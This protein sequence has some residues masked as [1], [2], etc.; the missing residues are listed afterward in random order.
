MTRA[1]KKA[2]DPSAQLSLQEI[3][4]RLAT[5]LETWKH[6]A[7][8]KAESE[9]WWMEILACYGVEGRR[10]R[11]VETQYEVIR[12]DTG[13]HGWIDVFWPGKYLIE[14]KSDGE[15]RVAPGAS[16]SNAEIQ[17][18]AYL[19]GG[20]L[21]ENQLPRYLV[22]SDFKVI[23]V[24]D[25]DA[26]FDESGPTFT[27]PV[28]DLVDNAERLMF[29]SG[30]DDE[31]TPITE[32]EQVSIK[33][34]KVMAKLFAALT[35]DSD[36]SDDIAD[37]DEETKD[38]S[39]LLTRLL[40]LMFGDDV[41]L[42]GEK[43]LFHDLIE[44]TRIDGTD[45][46]GTLGDLFEVLDTDY[47]DPRQRE[48]VN[49]FP[50]V[51]GRLFSEGGARIPS[52]NSEMRL[53]LLEACEFNWTDIS[54]A[55]FG[56]LFQTVHSRKAR[57]SG[58]EHYTTETN[59]LKTI[60]PLFLDELWDQ[61][62]RARSKPDYERLHTHIASLRFVDPACGCGNFLVVAYR[63][64]RRLELELL[65]RLEPKL[66]ARRGQVSMHS[67]SLELRQRVTPNQFSGIEIKWWPARIAQ[68]AMFLIDHQ[69]NTE[70]QGMVHIAPRLPIRDEFT[71]NIIHGNAMKLDWDKELPAGEG[72]VYVFGNPPFLGDHSRTTEQVEELQMAWGESTELSRLDYVTG[73]YAKSLRYFQT[74]NGEFAF[75][76]TNSITQG[77]QPHRLF[78]AIFH[79]GWRIKFAHQTFAWDSETTS[80]E[81]AAVHCVIIGYTREKLAQPRL[82]TYKT[83]QDL[84]TEESATRHINPYLVDGPDIWVGKRTSPLCPDLPA[85]QYGSKA[86][87]GSR[88]WRNASQMPG[89]SATP[90]RVGEGNLLI[91]TEDELARVQADPIAAKYVRP[92]LGSDELING[93]TRWCLWLT[94]PEPSVDQS[95][96]LTAR[97]DAVKAF[98]YRSKAPSTVEFAEYHSYRF[99]QIGVH[100]VPF[101]GIPEV[102]SENR[103]YATVTRFAENVIPSNKVYACPDPDGFAFA[104]LSSAMFITWQKLVGGRLESRPSFSSTIVWNNLPLPPITPDQ[105]VQI[106]K[107]GERVAEVRATRAD[108]TLAQQYNPRALSPELIKAHKALDRKVDKAFGAVGP[109]T[110]RTRQQVLMSGFVKLA[111]GE[112]PSFDFGSVGTVKGKVFIASSIHG[113]PDGAA[114]RARLAGR[115]ANAGFIPYLAEADALGGMDQEKIDRNIEDSE[116]FIAIVWSSLGSK[117]MREIDKARHTAGLQVHYFIG[118]TEG[119]RAGRNTAT[120]AYLDGL[121]TEEKYRHRFET[122]ASLIELV[123]EQVTR[124]RDQRAAM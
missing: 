84:P 39:I 91:F 123:V 110:L 92:F 8:E 97:F 38:A 99:R 107:A 108:L 49:A 19:T 62:E 118:D 17:A 9:R 47:R 56:S 4:R 68:T 33:A 121:R 48:L 98:R 122:D 119:Q 30:V 105:R 18:E 79:A 43:R 74:H 124:A 35:H 32:Q 31:I 81:K 2:P 42:W 63:E 114:V 34:A 115:L 26:L 44:Q 78:P 94:Q 89:W 50:K 117:T 22:T 60:K 52:F 20:S 88:E 87:D 82:F 5:F 100:G 59:I 111:G 57:R 77:D 10:A 27:I 45:I 75:V 15:L 24:T 66:G 6:A 37:T 3:R 23:Q 54:P 13:R 51:N 58:G 55:V 112:A 25:R 64:L 28:S 86:V 109:Q 73:W 7:S 106:I 120:A 95:K 65:K 83:P 53:A 21:T 71:A 12:G 103:P 36:A 16:K 90:P 69:I 29:L 70:M 61:L 104:I 14:H 76:S 46:K 67:G 102:F 113:Y 96:V 80:K 41:G 85:V 1:A 101:L 11:V 116:H 72:Q 40:F 93:K